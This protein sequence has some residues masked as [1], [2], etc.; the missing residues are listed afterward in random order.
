MSPIGSAS[1]PVGRKTGLGVVVTAM[2]RWLILMWTVLVAAG[3]G[4][5]AALASANHQGKSTLASPEHQFK[6][7]VPL[8]IVARPNPSTAGARVT[9]AGR[10]SAPSP[11]GA[12]VVLWERPTGANSFRRIATTST[13]ASGRYRFARV[14]ESQRSWYVTSR[15][16]RSRIVTEQVRAKI[17]LASSDQYP[18][19]GDHVRLIGQVVPSHAGDRVMLQRREG[20]AWKVVATERL[21][22]GS[23]FVFQRTLGQPTRFAFRA[24]LAATA[25][26]LWSHSPPLL[27]SVSEIH[28]IKHMV[29]IMQENRSFDQYFGTFRGATGIPGLAGN[30]GS[31]PCIPDPSQTG[32]CDKPF[33]DR[34]DE[35]FGG[36]HLS[37][38]ATVDMNCSNPARDRG[39]HMNGFAIEASRGG[40]CTGTNPLCSPCKVVAKSIC[41]DVMGYHTGADI[42]NY[43]R[44]A[45]DY[46]LQDHMFEPAR[47]WSVPAHLFLVSEWA[48]KCRSAYKPSSCRSY[49]GYNDRPAKSQYAWTDITYLLHR[50]RISWAY[51][52][53]K[54]IEPDCDSNTQVTCQPVR[55]GPKTPSI[56]NPLPSFTDVGQDH[57]K[58]DVRSL[59][60]FFAAARAGALPAVSWVIPDAAVSEHPPSLVSRGQ[61][62][63]TGLI[64]AI[65]QSREW[66]ST[67]IFLAWDDWGGFYD[68]VVPPRVDRNGY[69]LRV[70][71]MVISP[72]ARRGFIDDQTLSFD[73]YNKFIEDDFLNGQRL[74]P[75]TDGRPDSRPDVRESNPRLGDLA[76]DFNFKQRPRPPAILPVCPATDL[77]PKPS[78]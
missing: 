19:P 29:V 78:C 10:L 68:Q 67:A 11:V 40:H 47:S 55:Q 32:R 54:G 53:Y 51:Y 3:A 23:R 74:N 6:P 12:T 42:P 41:P 14:A 18:V 24:V 28:K 69:G 1:V 35:N 44:Y 38:S 48:A 75:A 52:L 63:V 8:T 62:Y 7:I 9:V 15:G 76:R 73:A 65:M 22:A 21:S 58:H 70:P 57:Q 33:H 37:H 45:R 13:D 50:S 71:A 60:A 5:G 30:P 64:N 49:L 17:S 61:T 4:G 2:R 20:S 26:N 27:L 59:T 36:P 34:S 66:R 31:E 16:L 46:V 77:R 43:W 56:W 72:Y 25:G 39:C